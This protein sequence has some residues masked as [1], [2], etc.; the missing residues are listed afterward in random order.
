[1]EDQ[2][3]T[4]SN[5]QEELVSESAIRADEREKCRAELRAKVDRLVLR[6]PDEVNSFV[7]E[8]DRWANEEAFGGE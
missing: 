2:A 5:V 6:Y 3:V 7:A 8:I 4:W 1:M